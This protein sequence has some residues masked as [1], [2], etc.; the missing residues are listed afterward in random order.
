MAKKNKTFQNFLIIFLA[1]AVILPLSYFFLPVGQYSPPPQGTSQEDI[2]ASE[3]QRER[4]MTDKENALKRIAVETLQEGEG[5]KQASLGDIV[6]VHYTGTLEDG[7][8]FD[9]SLD[10]DQPFVFLLGGGQ[11]IRGWDFG[12]E[13]MRVGEKRK[14]AI[15]PD[16]AYGET[17]TPN[18]PIPPNATLTFEIELLQAITPDLESLGAEAP[19][20]S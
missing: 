4:Y 6:S 2:I 14:L 5:D 8:K 15:P 18:G 11:V 9:S 19:S 1:V 3:E 17:G 12:V 7:T 16:L 13:G 10:R 20:G